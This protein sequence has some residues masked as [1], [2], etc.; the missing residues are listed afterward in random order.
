MQHGVGI[1]YGWIVGGQFGQQG[2]MAHFLEHVE[3][4]VAGGAIG[5]QAQS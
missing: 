4:V 5:T 2:G 3:T 1:E